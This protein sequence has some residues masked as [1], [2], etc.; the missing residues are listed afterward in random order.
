MPTRA[1]KKQRQL[2]RQKL[3]RV[4][5]ADYARPL[6]HLVKA[7]TSLGLDVS[8][9]TQYVNSTYTDNVRV[10]LSSCVAHF[11]KPSP[12]GSFGKGRFHDTKSPCL[13]AS[14]DERTAGI[15]R[16]YYLLKNPSIVWPFELASYEIIATGTYWD[17]RD[18]GDADVVALLRSDDWTFAQQVAD[19]A[20]KQDVDGLI[21]LSARSQGSN[22]ATFRSDGVKTGQITGFWKVFKAARPDDVYDQRLRLE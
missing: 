20:R 17:T 6:Q 21:A 4:M 22:A 11:F 10:V 7:M 3:H 8:E 19:E 9:A 15:E 5:P 16:S 14:F 2:T 18:C 1:L 13:Y 12:D